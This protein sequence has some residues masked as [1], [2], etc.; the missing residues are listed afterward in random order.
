VHRRWVVWL[1]GG[2]YVI[3]D[4]AEGA[5][6]H[7]LRLRWR[8]GPE[9]RIAGGEG[10]A[11]HWQEQS[12]ETAEARPENRGS[13]PGGGMRFRG[14]AGIVLEV[15]P[16][17]DAAS[18]SQISSA[19]WSPAYGRKLDALVICSEKQTTLPA[20]FATAITV[21]RDAVSPGRFEELQEAGESSVKAYEYCHQ[22]RRVLTVFH[23]GE[24]VW[25]WRGWSSD[26][27][28][29]VVETGAGER[30]GRRVFLAKGSFLE[31]GGRRVLGC[32]NPVECWEWLRGR[33]EEQIYCSEPGA[34]E[35]VAAEAL[36]DASPWDG[37]SS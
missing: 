29:L 7:R 3:R 13:A 6:S 12:K 24:G 8:L 30:R 5:G 27:V 35:H 23:D 15:I 17:G 20:G 4:V 21:A 14:P 10:S 16:G 31:S 33:A 37:Q 25:K 22:S 18:Q 28:L 9:F 26:A 1:G 2:V 19:A 36:R 32:R 34:V 11:G